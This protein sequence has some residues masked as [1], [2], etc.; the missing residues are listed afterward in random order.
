MS[1]SVLCFSVTP[2]GEVYFLLGKQARMQSG[3]ATKISD[4]W[5]DFGGHATER[6]SSVAHTA[7]REF[8]EESMCCVS[9]DTT[10]NDSRYSL[11]RAALTH[12]LQSGNYVAAITVGCAQKTQGHVCYL[13]QIPWDP[14][15]PHDFDALRKTLFNIRTVSVRIAWMLRKPMLPFMHLVE[16]WMNTVVAQHG[17]YR[18]VSLSVHCLEGTVTAHY[19]D[20]TD[21]PHNCTVAIPERFAVEQVKAFGEYLDAVK[22]MHTMHTRLPAG[23]QSHPA[24]RC[25]RW[26]GRVIRMMVDRHYL[27]MQCIAWWSLPAMIDW[28]RHMGRNNK[29][30]LRPCFLPT[31]R[32]ALDYLAVHHNT[33]KT[34]FSEHTKVEKRNLFGSPKLSAQNLVQ[35]S[36]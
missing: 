4:M 6:D 7:S 26:R 9:T 33:H 20:A 25:I 21:T 16:H 17:G 32:I 31:I 1:A 27:E 36:T 30:M 2:G 15:V 29:S 18:V 10:K 13:R 14:R 11:W 8:L 5:C 28:V 19:V 34:V 23:W 12:S 24:L 22:S 3:R 35:V